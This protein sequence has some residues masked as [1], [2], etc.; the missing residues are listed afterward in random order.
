M[1]LGFQVQAISMMAN[2]VGGA[3]VHRD[4]KE[5]PATGFPCRS[6]RPIGSVRL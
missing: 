4:R 5:I 1:T 3:F 6:S 2:W